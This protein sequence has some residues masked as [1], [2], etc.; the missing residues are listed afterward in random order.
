M[1]RIPDGDARLAR[2]RALPTPLAC[3]LL[4]SLDNPRHTVADRYDCIDVPG[5]ADYHIRFLH[6]QV[7][8]LR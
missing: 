8:A 3:W 6:G 5:G 1:S 2:C 7:R 4:E